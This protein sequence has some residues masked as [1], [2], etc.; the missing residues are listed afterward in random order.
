[1]QASCLQGPG[2]GPQP[3]PITMPHSAP[4]QGGPLRQIEFGSQAVEIVRGRVGS[5]QGPTAQR[6]HRARL[7]NSGAVKSSEAPPEAPNGLSFHFI[8][9]ISN[10]VHSSPPGQPGV[11][12]RAVF[13]FQADSAVSSRTMRTSVTTPSS[14]RSAG[15]WA[16]AR[17]R[18]P[19][20]YLSPCPPPL[21]S[22]TPS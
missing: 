21:T 20:C 3:R 2:A 15:R 6:A 11:V 8:S 19:A 18:P 13:V 22:R 16:A 4:A 5:F 10:S 14:S 1:M 12:T 17:P 7:P 9:C